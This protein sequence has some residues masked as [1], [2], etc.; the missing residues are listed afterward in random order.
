MNQPTAISIGFSPCPNDTFI[1]DA[2]IHHKINNEYDWKVTLADVEAL[3][4]FAAQQHFDVTKLSF[5]AWLQL[6]EHYD[7]LE[8][9]SALGQGCGPLLI[10]KKQLDLSSDAIRIAIPGKLTTANFLFSSCFSNLKNQTVPMLFSSI[11]D[12][13][14]SGDVDAGVIIH[15]NR[16]TYADKGL[17]LIVDLGSWWEQTTQTAIPLGGIVIKKS[18]TEAEKKAIGNLIRQSTEYAFSQLPNL[19][20]YV[21]EHAQEMDESVMRKHIDLYVNDYTLALGE[22]GHTAINHMKAYYEKALSTVE[23]NSQ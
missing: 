23:K 4:Q 16:F 20:S 13:V 2:L 18:Y 5:F 19:S 22:K 14:L 3:N 11:E 1:F 8:S 17:Q 10:S 9:G 6:Q 21:K 12:A 15:E 7:L